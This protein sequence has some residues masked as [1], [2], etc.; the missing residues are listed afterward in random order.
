MYFQLLL[1]LTTC[2]C[3]YPFPSDRYLGCVQSLPSKTMLPWASY[4]SPYG[5]CTKGRD[6]EPESMYTL[7]FPQLVLQMLHQLALPQTCL[8]GSH[9]PHPCQP[10]ILFD[11]LILA[12][13]LGK[14]MTSGNFNLH[15]A[16]SY[17]HRLML[18]NRSRFEVKGPSKEKR[19]SKNQQKSR[20]DI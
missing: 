4:L 1:F 16:D 6:A 8:A 3:V 13:H 10:L 11:F 17:W 5:L 7:S 19:P 14:K 18:T 12:K 9:L 15:I 2:A 20:T